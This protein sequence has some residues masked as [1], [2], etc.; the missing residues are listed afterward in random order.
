MKKS[1]FL[2]LK[3]IICALLFS[4]L[5]YSMDIYVSSHSGND[6]NAATLESPLKSIAKALEMAYAGD[7]VII[8]A[9][10]YNEEINFPRSGNSENGAITL[11]RFENEEVIIDGQG[12]TV[13]KNQEALIL[14]EDRSYI[15][16]NGLIIRNYQSSKNSV[17]PCGIRVEGSGQA[18][19]ITNNKIYDIKTNYKGGGNAHGMAIYGS[20]APESLSDI[21]IDGN[22][23][24]NLKLGSSEAMVLN[25]NVENFIVSNNYVHHTNNIGIDVIGHEG[26]SPDAKYDQA[27][28]GI[29]VANKVHAVAS[30]GNPAY[31]NSSSAGGIYVD[32]GRDILIDRNIVFDSD[33]GI[34][35]ASEHRSKATSRVIVRNNLLYDNR[36]TGIAIGGYDSLRGITEECFIVGNTLYHN[37]TLQDGNG[38]IY[39]QYYTYNNVFKNNIMV[40]FGE[41]ILISNRDSSG[42]RDNIFDS[43]L[44]YTADGK[45]AFFKWK[46]KT[47]NSFEDFQKTG[48]DPNSI[49]ENPLFENAV[50][51]NFQLTSTSPALE[52]GEMMAEVIGDLDLNGQDRVQGLLDLG[53]FERP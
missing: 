39:M 24:Y 3:L 51:G 33:I 48:L 7:R 38:E 5:A 29:I 53:A 52:R 42:N 25:G 43:N 27:R 22:E 1:N 35:I 2:N 19:K 18:I 47:Y 28:N 17:V 30:K 13:G 26:T 37:N 16:I 32:G 14:V 4:R 15:T 50:Q 20:R 31:G 10:L 45:E 44:Y 49:F 9:G 34:E 40:S 11:T 21:L 12:I 23:L 6:S 36:M 8:R 46:N 41:N